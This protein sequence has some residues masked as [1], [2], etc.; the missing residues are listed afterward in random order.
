MRILRHLLALALTALCVQGAFAAIPAGYY[1]SL[2]GKAEGDLKTAAYNLI[3][4]FTTVSSYSALPDYFRRT[5]ARPNTDLWWDMYAATPRRLYSFS[6]LN[7][8]HSFPKSWWGGSTS[9]SAYVDLNH[10]YPADGPAN[11][12]K[13]NY[14]LGVVDKSGINFDNGVSTVGYPV[15]NQGGGAAQVYEPDDEYKG[16]FARTYFYMVTCFQNLTWKYTYMLGQNL[17]PTL[18]PWAANLLMQ[19]HRQ[20]PVSQKEI[21]RNEV[22]YSIQGNRNPFIDLPELAEYL[23]GTKK[24]EKFTPGSVVVPPVVSGEPELMAPAIAMEAL[25]F[26]QV[27]LGKE[28]ITQ[29]YVKG[30]NLGG[31]VDV[32]L[33]RDDAAMFSIS[34]TSIPA[35]LVCADGG[36]WLEIRYTPTKLGKHTARILLQ[37][38]FGSRGVGLSGECLEVPVLSTLT[39]TAP[40]DIRSDRYTANW[41]AAPEG[42]VI[43]Y[44]IVTRTKYLT[45]GQPVTEEL[46]AESNSL[47]IDGFD[48]SDREAY[49][50]QSVRLD[51]RSQMSNVVFVDHSGITGVTTEE[52]LVVQTFP[53]FMRFICSAPQTGCRV[54]DSAG[55]IVLYIDSVEQNLDVEMPVGIYFV[56]T[57]Q[58]PTPVKVAVR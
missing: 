50:V 18:S 49:S 8:E 26:G 58:H 34:Q 20:D 13:S 45:G 41:S 37:G 39:A 23:W 33:Y 24:G 32:S 55:R 27:A 21:D 7:R 4:N 9:V 35:S 51:I 11:Q 44:Y 52:P 38:D 12:A 22:V 30:A 15:N 6:G 17:Y 48:E 57:D 16:D 2:N 54:Y 42:E 43:D 10:L 53:G 28:S 25:D 36:Y 31:T 19:W 14:P 40:T 5:D 1:S 47:E 46:V 3:H 56:V 29:L